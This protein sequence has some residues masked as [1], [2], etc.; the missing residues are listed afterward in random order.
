MGIVLLIVGKRYDI[1][2]W[3]ARSFYFLA[4]RVLDI[5]FEI[6]GEE[7]LKTKPALLLGNHQSMLDILYLG[8]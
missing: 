4:G 5:Q 6:E 8:P 1:D 7:Y 2:F 3:T